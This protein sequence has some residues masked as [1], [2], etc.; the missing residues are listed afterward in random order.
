MVMTTKRKKAPC[1][2]LE[3]EIFW[4]NFLSPFFS[5]CVCDDNDDDVMVMFCREKGSM[6]IDADDMITPLEMIL[7]IY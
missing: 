2:D 7:F 3:S 5:F 4:W 1:W 6:L